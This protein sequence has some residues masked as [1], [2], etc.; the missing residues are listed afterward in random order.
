MFY[1]DYDLI[2]KNL[3]DGYDSWKKDAISYFSDVTYW[4]LVPL[5]AAKVIDEDSKSKYYSPTVKEILE[6]LEK[7]ISKFTCHGRVDN[8]GRYPKIIIEGLYCTEF[9]EKDRQDFLS[10]CVDSEILRD[11]ENPSILYNRW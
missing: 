4:N 11:I 1:T 6:F 9:I 2:T 8:T 3:F 5:V 7:H 10:F